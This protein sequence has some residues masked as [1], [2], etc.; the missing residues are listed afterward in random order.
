MTMPRLDRSSIVAPGRNDPTAAGEAQDDANTDR[1]YPLP[2]RAAVWTA[3]VILPWS[4]IAGVVWW[5]AAD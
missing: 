3:A 1:P 4:V 5:I 2:V